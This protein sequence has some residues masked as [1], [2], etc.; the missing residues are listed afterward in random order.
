ML[1]LELNQT[2]QENFGAQETAKEVYIV[3]LIKSHINSWGAIDRSDGC[4]N[5]ATWLWDC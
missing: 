3:G 5:L 4:E 2:C 1:D